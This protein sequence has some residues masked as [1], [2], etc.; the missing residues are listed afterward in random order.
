MIRANEFANIAVP[1][2]RPLPVVSSRGDARD[3][4]GWFDAGGGSGT[5]VAIGG[6]LTPAAR[7]LSVEQHANRV[8]THL[9]DDG[10]RR[11]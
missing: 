10:D 2:V 9:R 7:G 3:N 5:D 8:L 4:A 1:W 11:P 6:D